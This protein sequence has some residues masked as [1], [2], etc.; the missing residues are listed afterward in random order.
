MK[1]MSTK[2]RQRF[3]MLVYNLMSEGVLVTDRDGLIREINPAFTKVTGYTLPDVYGKKPSILKSGHHNEQFYQN[4]WASIHQ[5]GSW[6]GEIWNRKKDGE[7]YIQKL[8]MMTLLDEEERT[9]GYLGIFSDITTTKKFEKRLHF[10]YTHDPL[11]ELANRNSFMANLQTV[12]AT[13]DGQDRIPTVVMLNLA[14][15]RQVNE[16][17]GSHF[18]DQLLQAVAQRLAQIIGQQGMVARMGGDEFAILLLSIKQLD[19]ITS[20]IHKIVSAFEQPFSIE[21]QDL[22][23]HLNIGI[24]IYPYDGT[25]GES[26]IRNAEMAMFLT[27]ETGGTSYRFYTSDMNDMAGKRLKLEIGLRKALERGE[28]T[29]YYQPKMELATNQIKGVEA[30]IRW[31]HPQRGLVSPGEFIPVAEETGLIIPIGAWVLRTACEQVVRWQKAG[32]PPLK[33]AVNLSGKQ[34]SQENL[35]GMIKQILQETGLSPEWLELEITESTAMNNVAQAIEIMNELKRHGISLSIDDFGTGYSSLSYISR[36]PISTL[37]IDQSFIRE[38]IERQDHMAIVKAII[39]L[40]KSL[41]LKV[42]AEGVEHDQQR[43]YLE[44]LDCHEIQGYLISPP[45][46]ANDLEKLLRD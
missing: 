45:V 27:K 2:V 46:P 8:K 30:L 29:V 41:Q 10:Q 19:E 26:L 42:I 43:D 15:F 31:Q 23:V 25:E 3:A 11:T 14:Q 20:V 18:G 9:L 12:L 13:A 32:L 37:K 6:E 39:S 38:M 35:V 5:K 44:Q 1:Q 4:M 36:F 7:I 17:F 40:S 34:F 33:L 22:A 21:D 16:S 24:S 28:L